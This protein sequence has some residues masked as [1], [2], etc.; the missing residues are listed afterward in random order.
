MP[1]CGWGRRTT[2]HHVGVPC[3]PFNSSVYY[4][5]DPGLNSEEPKRLEDSWIRPLSSGCQH[6][7]PEL[8][9]YLLWQL[10]SV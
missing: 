4:P 3:R 7:P 2:E 6:S 8:A 10:S 5:E 9:D 1:V